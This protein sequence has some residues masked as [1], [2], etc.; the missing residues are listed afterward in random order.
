VVQKTTQKLFFGMIVPCISMTAKVFP[1]GDG[2]NSHH[3]TGRSRGRSQTNRLYPCIY[4]WF[5]T[6]QLW[7]VGVV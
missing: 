6:K 2:L 4:F 7:N 3:V 5:N 1:H